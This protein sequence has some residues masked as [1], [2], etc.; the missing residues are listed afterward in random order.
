MHVLQVAVVSQLSPCHLCG[1]DGDRA[2]QQDYY[3]MFTR[4]TSDIAK[5]CQLRQVMRLNDLP[6][7]E[8]FSYGLPL[9]LYSF[10]A[11]L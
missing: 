6:G 7:V 9:V 2:G 11:F 4:L 8:S 10:A 5:Y 3:Y 1:D